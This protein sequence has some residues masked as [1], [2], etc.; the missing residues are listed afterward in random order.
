MEGTPD[1]P[2]YDPPRLPRDAATKLRDD[3]QAVLP[4]LSTGAVEALIDALDTSVAHFCA[5]ERRETRRRPSKI[6]GELR[7]LARH[8]ATLQ[9]ALR[10]LSQEA[11]LDVDPFEISPG[12][13][14][15]ENFLAAERPFM[16]RNPYVAAPRTRAARRKPRTPAPPSTYYLDPVVI[17]LTRL[18]KAINE[19]LSEKNR[20]GAPLRQPWHHLAWQ[21]AGAIREHLGVEPTSRSGGKF[22]DLLGVCLRVG[23]EAIGSRARIPED[24]RTYTRSAIRSLKRSNP[25]HK[26]FAE[27][28]EVSCVT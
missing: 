3:I 24:L 2:N 13:E 25:E 17:T 6:K 27:I 5:W 19:R 28:V 8:V 12:F 16:K 4:G 21:V 7:Q 22:E 20:S 11:R 14:L 23:V 10:R 18:Q 9:S 1:E 15:P 26:T